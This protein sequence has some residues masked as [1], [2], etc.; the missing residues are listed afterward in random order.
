[1]FAWANN[2]GGVDQ[3]TALAKIVPKNRIWIGIF[4]QDVREERLKLTGFQDDGWTT[5]ILAVG[6]FHSACGNLARLLPICPAEASEVHYSPFV[7]PQQTS[8]RY[9]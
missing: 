5:T 3:R 8:S 4:I 6:L 2:S 9:W 7:L 1:L